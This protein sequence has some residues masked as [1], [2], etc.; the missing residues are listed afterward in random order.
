MK[1]LILK[2]LTMNFEKYQIYLKIEKYI[3][4]YVIGCLTN[5]FIQFKYCLIMSQLPTVNIL[6]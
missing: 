1:M 4:R 3:Y 5:N 2:I 6:S